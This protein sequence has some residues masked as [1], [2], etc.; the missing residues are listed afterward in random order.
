VK[1]LVSQQFKAQM[2]RTA[3]FLQFEAVAAYAAF[4][5]SGPFGGVPLPA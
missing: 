5:V 1:R 4:T 3:E 2:N